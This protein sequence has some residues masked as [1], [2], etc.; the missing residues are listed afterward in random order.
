VTQLFVEIM[1]TMISHYLPFVIHLIFEIVIRG[2]LTV[3]NFQRQIF[4]SKGKT[5]C[6]FSSD[7]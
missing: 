7:F 5:V 6:P 2:A 4:G 3:G 1:V